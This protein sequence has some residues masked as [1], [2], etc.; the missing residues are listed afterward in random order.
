MRSHELAALAG[1][2]IRTLRHYH[3]I[4]LLDEP[5]RSANGYRRYTVQ[6]L[7]VMLRIARFT[8]LG[9]P[10]S[11]VHRVLD[12]ADAT[13][14]LLEELDAQAAAEI[15]RLERRRARIATLAGGISPD[16]P[17]ALVPFASLLTRPA[18]T[19]ESRFE[20]EQLAL[21]EHLSDDPT[22]PWLVAATTRLA[23]TDAYRPL[24]D[25]FAALAPDAAT[26]ETE[27]LADELAALLT[28]ATPAEAIPTLDPRATELLLAH[29]WANLNPAQ[30]AVTERLVMRLSEATNAS[31]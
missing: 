6:H 15:E 14:R 13:A 19:R 25:R 26:S 3:Q 9:I 7:A 29:Q 12:D 10:L 2:S 11:E 17:A 16:T 18:P 20:R 28:D 1:V 27:A 30:R 5:E 4:G 8:E 22:L 31:R 24:V 23:D 21:I